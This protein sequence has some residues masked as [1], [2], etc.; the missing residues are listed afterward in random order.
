MSAGQR[1]KPDARSALPEFVTPEWLRENYHLMKADRRKLAAAIGEEYQDWPAQADGND[2]AAFYRAVHA[3]SQR[4]TYFLWLFEDRVLKTFG[5]VKGRRK[6]LGPRVLMSAWERAKALRSDAPGDREPTVLDDLDTLCGAGEHA[7]AAQSVWVLSCLDRPDSR[8][9]VESWIAKPEI[10]SLVGNAIGGGGLGW[11]PVRDDLVERLDHETCGPH[12]EKLVSRAD[13]ECVSLGKEIADAYGRLRK[14][15]SE[16]CDYRAAEDAGLSSLFLELEDLAD[17]LHEIVHARN[18]ALARHRHFALRSLLEETVEA[19]KETR[20]AEEADELKQRVRSLLEDAPFR[21]PDP[22][23]ENCRELASRFRAAIIEPGMHEMALQEASRRYAENPSVENR[24]ALHAAASAER[25]NVRSTEPARTALDEISACLSGLV[26]RFSYMD[27][28]VEEEASD[29]EALDPEPLL[30]AEISE[31]RTAKRAAEERIATLAQTLQ[32]AREENSELRREKHRMQQRLAPPGEGAGERVAQDGRTVPPLGSYAHLPAWAERHFQGRVAL[33]GRALR[34]V[35]S[36]EFEDVG[37][38]G[39]AIELLGGTYY[40]MKSE[41]GKELRDL[42][43]EE[44]R[45]LRLLE[46]PSLSPDRQGKARDDFSMEWNG[47]RLTL[48]R[49]LKN[50]AK[51]RDPKHCFRLYFAWDDTTR[52]VVIGHLPGHMKT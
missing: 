41:G 5:R 30:R 1:D 47:R 16:H 10:G 43:D 45:G 52:Q 38:V 51:T 48:D 29:G 11:H 32:D 26:K 39:K 6:Q 7:L 14:H 40:R 18:G 49:H 3:F 27:R 28:S 8:P 44:L 33:S 2:E 42:F 37:L 46:T 4:W 19:M 31:L 20:F 9:M 35:K 24:D 34:A 17:D 13:A 12:L 15:V 22:D 50:N 25:E 23:W 36:A 21:F